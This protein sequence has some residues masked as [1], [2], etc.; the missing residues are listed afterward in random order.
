MKTGYIAIDQYNNRVTLTDTKHPRKQLLNKLGVKS[1]QTIY[2]D[3]DGKS[4]L[5]G[6]IVRGSWYSIYAIHAWDGK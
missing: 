1:A 3:V 2:R 5:D 6:Y 4:K